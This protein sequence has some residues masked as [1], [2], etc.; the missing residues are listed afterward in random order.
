MRTTPIPA[1]FVWE[2]AH[3]QT[4]GPPPGYE[5]EIAPVDAVVDWPESIPGQVRLS[6]RCELEAGDLAKLAAGGHVWISFYGQMVPF[7]VD[8]TGPDGR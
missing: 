1:E 7:S 4:I 6:V 3:T 5:A 2:G 8:V